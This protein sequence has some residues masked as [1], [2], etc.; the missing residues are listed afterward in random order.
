LLFF[1]IASVATCP[2]KLNERT[3]KQSTLAKQKLD[4]FVASQLPPEISGRDF[5][6]R[7]LERDGRARQI[8]EGKS[9]IRGLLLRFRRGG[10]NLRDRLSAVKQSQWRDHVKL[11]GFDGLVFQQE[12]PDRD[13]IRATPESRT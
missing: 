12:D 2:P 8:R 9:A 13:D 4:C 7:R 5:G 6:E 11:M 10:A 1:V 3:Q